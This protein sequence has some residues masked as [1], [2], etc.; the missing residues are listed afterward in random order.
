[1]ISKQ[2]LAKSVR[3]SSLLTRT[4]ARQLRP[5]TRRRAIDQLAA[6]TGRK[7]EERREMTDLKV[8]VPRQHED[9]VVSQPSVLLGVH[10]QRDPPVIDEPTLVS[11]FTYTLFLEVGRKG[12]REQTYEL[13]RGEPIPAGVL[14]EL[15]HRRLGVEEVARS[16]GS[17][18]RHRALCK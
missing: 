11:S 4:R 7:G 6:L 1:L 16:G 18:V 17:R 8:D 14:L 12:M 3:S 15:V 2:R 9:I 5:G 13:L 10:L